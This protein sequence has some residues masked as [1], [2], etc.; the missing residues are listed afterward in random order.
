MSVEITLRVNGLDR[1]SEVSSKPPETIV[2]I[3]QGLDG[4]L[5]A[6]YDSDRQRFAVSYDPNRVTILRIL[7]RIEFAGQGAGRP[8][9]PSDVQRS[10][11]SS[12]RSDGYKRAGEEL[13]VPEEADLVLSEWAGSYP[14]GYARARA[15]RVR[16]SDS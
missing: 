16:I 9:R 4:V 11:E 13:P 12:F 15:R 8:Y 14:A 10:Q 3:L 6:R 1:S 2:R 5:A 7:S